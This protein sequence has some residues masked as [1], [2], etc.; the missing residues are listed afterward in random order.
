[1]HIKLSQVICA[2]STKT[3][4]ESDVIVPDIKPDAAK[5]LRAGGEAV[6]TQ[7]S[8]QTDKVYVE[9]IIRLDILYVP[10]DKSCGRIKSIS[11]DQ[12]F[13]HMIAANGAKP[14]MDV[15][16]AVV[17][18]SPEYNLINSRKIGVRSTLCINIKVTENKE[19]DIAAGIEDGEDIQAKARP[20]R[21]HNSC[22]CAERDILIKD[23]IEVPSGKP[24]LKEILRFSA[25]PEL[26][27]L[28]LLSGKVVVK[29]T[30]K[31]CTLYSGKGEEDVLEC[32]EHSVPFSEV[33]EI[34][35]VDESLT[36]D[37]AF[38][39]KDIYYEI[40]RDGDGDKRLLSFE[41][42]LC[43]EIKTSGVIECEAM[44]DAYSLKKEV[45]LKKES[46]AIEQLVDIVAQ[47]ISLKE[48]ARVPDY[49][50]EV[51]QV[52]DCTAS[53]EIER[54][55]VEGKA[56]NIAGYITCNIL[57]MSQS[58]DMP[59]SGFSHV[60]PFS[61]SIEVDGIAENSVCDAKVEIEHL[62]Y[63]ISGNREIELRA[64]LNIG[65]KAVNPNSCEIVS[66]LEYDDEKEIPKRAA[67]VV[68]FV[69]KGDTLWDVAKRYRTTPEAIVAANG[70]EKECMVE[71]KRIYI[72]R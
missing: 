2:R 21:F 65:L 49:L 27:E 6:I 5:I 60:L 51:Y 64:V 67:M 18:L 28:R 11:V 44:C 36:G 23:K 47:E 12:S 53:G 9:G 70:S 35:G 52:C 32:M 55:S 38:C 48:M 10:E 40:C 66:E 24:D 39:V 50:P 30:L 13:S 41:M 1:E 33:L 37:V 19:V 14:G 56:V 72:F 57:Y 29:G 25:K 31:I 58:E 3:T 61:H 62:G 54:I 20:L 71:G 43:V 26:E 8:V 22:P 45:K 69:Q 63:I 42:A 15:E 4:V 34:D 59:V 7:K 68:Y 46:C 16:A 17:S